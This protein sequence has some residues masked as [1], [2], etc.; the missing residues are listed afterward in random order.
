LLRQLAALKAETT[1][2]ASDLYA[3]KLTK[4]HLVETVE[5]VAAKASQNIAFGRNTDDLLDGERRTTALLSQQLNNEKSVTGRLSSQLSVEKL[6]RAHLSKRM[7]AKSRAAS[8]G[9]KVQKELDLVKSKTSRLASEL[10]VEKLAKAQLFEEVKAMKEMLPLNARLRWQLDDL[11][12]VASRL[13]TELEMEKVEKANLSSEMKAKIQETTQLQEAASANTKLLQE[14]NIMKSK[15]KRLASELYM[16]KLAKAQLS[17]EVKGK[18]DAVS[19]KAKLR[20]ELAEQKSRTGKLVSELFV[21][22]ITKA[23]LSGKREAEAEKKTRLQLSNFEAEKLTNLKLLRRLKNI[24]LEKARLS[25]ALVA[26]RAAKQSA[27]VNQTLDAAKKDDAMSAN[28]KLWQAL[29]EEKSKT[30]RLASEL[31][32]EKLAKAELS[33]AV[34]SMQDTLPVNKKLRKEVDGLKSETARLASALFVEKVTKSTLTEEVTEKEEALARERAAKAKLEM[35]ATL[36]AGLLKQLMAKH[37]QRDKE[38]QPLPR[39][40]VHGISESG[41]MFSP[42]RSKPNQSCGI[43]PV[44]DASLVHAKLLREL[45]EER[46][47][48]GRLASE[49]YVAKLAKAQLSLA[50]NSRS[51]TE[52]AN[53]RLAQELKHAKTRMDRL[54]AELFTEKIAGPAVQERA[55]PRKADHSARMSRVT[56]DSTVKLKVRRTDVTLEKSAVT[57]ARSDDSRTRSASQTFVEK[58]AQ[59]QKAKKTSSKVKFVQDLV[60]AEIQET[61]KTSEYFVEKI[62]KGT[63]TSMFSKISP[64]ATL[65]LQ[66]QGSSDVSGFANILSSVLML[67]L[68]AFALYS[69]HTSSLQTERV[70]VARLEDELQQMQETVMQLEREKMKEPSLQLPASDMLP[71]CDVP[72][73]PQPLHLATANAPE[74]SFQLRVPEPLPTCEPPELPQPL[75]LASVTHVDLHSSVV[76]QAPEADGALEEVLDNITEVSSNDVSDEFEIIEAAGISEL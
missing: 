6:V 37:L 14:L 65:D 28:A 34:R 57:H 36:T 52:F 23:T 50:A 72:E 70:K 76:F 2:L 49:L 48:S 11:K 46:S 43:K 53:A 39:G 54:T 10:F 1:K 8:A 45:D 21:E 4:A 19:E 56:Q 25:S 16:E 27:L 12:G 63:S 15:T 22:K 17:W 75:S 38:R 32:V 59:V 60:G 31:F 35:N 51:E 66:A 30:G 73:L 33:Q 40:N 3:E 44:T 18:L 58:L 64:R 68:S 26:E 24:K 5:R 61:G 62:P 7:K 69:K 71:P 47:K 67:G 74:R 29:D 9:T 41:S 55:E 13:G 20:R 42:D